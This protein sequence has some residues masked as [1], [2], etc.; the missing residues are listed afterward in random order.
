MTDHRCPHEGSTL[1]EVLVA[2]L[3][4][5]SGVLTMAQLFLIAAAA[6]ASARQVTVVATLAAQKMEQVLSSE[7][8]VA[9][10]SVDHVDGAGRVLGDAHDPPSDAVYTRRSSIE[11]LTA[12]SVVIRV[13]VGRSDRSGRLR[14]MSGEIEMLTIKRRTR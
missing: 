11:A 13:R 8:A 4:L 9:P 10:D 6:N 14:R 2:T 3:V 7:M 1:I 5:V 12:D